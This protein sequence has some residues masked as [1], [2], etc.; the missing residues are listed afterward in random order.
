MAIAVSRKFPTGMR[1]NS[2]HST[3]GLWEWNNFAG[4]TAGAVHLF[5]CSD[6]NLT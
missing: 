2:R 4:I 5:V 6:N 3:V 1:M